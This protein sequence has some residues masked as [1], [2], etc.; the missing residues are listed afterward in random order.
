MATKGK[1]LVLVACLA[2]MGRQ[3]TQERIKELIGRGF[4][5][6]GDA[7]NSLGDF[8]GRLGR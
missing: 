6:H 3:A 7:E 1:V 2:S 5:K 4:S 8:L